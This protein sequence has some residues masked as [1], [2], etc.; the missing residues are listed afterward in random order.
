MNRLSL[1]PERR[2]ASDISRLE[3]I[4]EQLKDVQFMGYDVLTAKVNQT[5]D[6]YDLTSSDDGF[7]SQVIIS[8][9][10]FTSDNQ[11]SV[12]ATIALIFYDDS[13]SELAQSYFDR[14]LV[15]P[16]FVGVVDNQAKFEIDAEHYG[17]SPFHAKI[18][19][20]ATDT[21]GISV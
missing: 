12:F 21:G 7:G 2:V 14:I 13:G 18:F 5:D 20:L 8:T 9:I 19:I 10:T 11:P 15:N 6:T 16:S 1:K 3:N 17:A 4:V